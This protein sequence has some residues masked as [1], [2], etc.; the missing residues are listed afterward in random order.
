MGK[1]FGTDG[2]RG[3][4]NRYPLD[5]ATALAVGQAVTLILRKSGRTPLV[6]IGRDT[7][8]SG[9][10]L[11]SAFAA[12]V[13]SMGGE[14][15]PLGVMPTPA[16]AFLTRSLRADA[17]VMIT[18]SHNPFQDNGIKIFTGEGFKL[19]DEQEERVE[20]FVLG[21]GLG[22]ATPPPSEMGSLILAE[23]APEHYVEFLQSTVPS[24]VSLEGL[25][26]VLD[27]ANGATYEVAPAVFGGLGADATVIH[28]APNG[29]NINQD[30][31]SQHTG[32]LSKA[33]V[34]AAPRRSGLRRRR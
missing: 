4:A 33:V 25:K 30:C 7:R 34:R 21:D 12:G 19:S 20:E 22:K 24:S 10:M 29:I 2:I 9:H 1:L 26:I 13:M 11:E 14:A 5:A 27:T 16:V 3:E 17:G 28:N 32:D 31:G 18:A 15:C 23:G 8:L 6:L